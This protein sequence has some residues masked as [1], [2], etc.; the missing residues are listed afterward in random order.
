MDWGTLITEVVNGSLDMLIKIAVIIFPL[1][2]GIEVADEIGLLDQIA[3]I[4][5]PIL[6]HFKLSNDAGLPLIVAQMFGLTYGA[7]VILKEV[8]EDKLHAQ[9][10][11]TLAV[12]LVICHAVIEDTLLFVAIGGKGWIM[13]GTRL[14][15]AVVIS[16]LYAEYFVDRSVIEEKELAEADCC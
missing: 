14:L 1:L 15:L 6:K 4:F 9:E 5:T 16:Y 2:I 7:G 10:L 3:K 11:M 8:E 13:L 12:F